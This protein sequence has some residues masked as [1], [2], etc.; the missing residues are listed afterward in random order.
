MIIE[1]V[2]NKDFSKYSEILK[3][4][5]DLGRIFDNTNNYEK[6]KCF[7]KKLS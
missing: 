1:A 4:R 3:R 6:I 5:E 7:F 2:P